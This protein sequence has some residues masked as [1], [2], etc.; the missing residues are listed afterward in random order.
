M[1]RQPIEVFFSYSCE[2]KPWRDKLETYL[3]GLK[4]Q[5]MI[6]SWHDRQIVAG[7]EW[8]EEIDRH[9]QTADLILLLISPNFVNSKYCYE[10][11]LPDAMARHEAGEAYVVP[12]LLRPVV[13]WQQ[14]PFAKLQVYPSGSKPITEWRPQQKAFVDV[15]EGI[16]VAVEQLLKD[17][18][19]QK[20]LKAEKIRQ[21]TK[22]EHLS[23]EQANQEQEKDLFEDEED[24]ENLLEDDEKDVL[25]SGEASDISWGVVVFWGIIATLVFV[26]AS[27]K[28]NPTSPPEIVKKETASTGAEAF[29]VSGVDKQN[30]G[31]YKGALSDYAQ[32]IKLKP[33][34]ADVF[35]NGGLARLALSD[36]QGAITDFKKA[37]DL[38]G[39]QGN[40]ERLKKALSRL[41]ELQP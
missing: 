29:F 2:D 12:I 27:P 8:E 22:Q 10:I 7:S 13:G 19:E 31:D 14:L 36:K 35:Y 3:S 15:A 38:Y 30:Q 23:I 41:K 6:T 24:E 25:L 26:N 9:M 20:Q 28:S 18:Q 4:R 39:K 17:R 5:G 34:Y 40:N 21:D 16:A 32:A 11:E 1:E 37:V 33:D